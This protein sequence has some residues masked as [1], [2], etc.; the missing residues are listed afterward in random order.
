MENIQSIGVPLLLVNMDAN[1][2]ILNLMYSSPSF[3]NKSYGVL[4]PVVSIPFDSISSNS[5][6]KPY[7]NVPL[8]KELPGS[9]DLTEYGTPPTT[10]SSLAL[11]TIGV[12]L[13]RPANIPSKLK[14]LPS[15]SAWKLLPYSKNLTL[16]FMVFKSLPR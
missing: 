6:L 14:P 4:I 13:K 3:F 11:L 5:F 8:S 15:F 12:P 1:I 7:I 16:S 2:P 9:D 10:I